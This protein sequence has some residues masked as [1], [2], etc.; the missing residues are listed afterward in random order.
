MWNPCS[1]LQHTALSRLEK[2]WAVVIWKNS[3]LSLIL[4]VADLIIPGMGIRGREA[5]LNLDS[6]EIKGKKQTVAKLY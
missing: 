5:R 6:R 1:T 2:T 4:S 3:S